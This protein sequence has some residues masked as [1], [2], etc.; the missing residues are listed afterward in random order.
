M[1]KVGEG[2]ELPKQP[3]IQ[4]YQEQ[5]DTNTIKFMNALE[6]Y[7]DGDSEEKTHFK[8][9]MDQALGMIRSAVQEIKRPGIAK[10]ES[11]V[12]KDYKEYMQNESSQNLSKLEEDV[13]TLRDYNKLG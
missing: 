3:S 9:V 10:Q 1:T 11:L 6:G 5:L 7:K 2:K 8:G 13:S 12:E 4:D